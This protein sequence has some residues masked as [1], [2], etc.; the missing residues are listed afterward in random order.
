LNLKRELYLYIKVIKNISKKDLRGVNIYATREENII[1]GEGGGTSMIFV[2]T[3][4]NNYQMYNCNAMLRNNLNTE[5][6]KN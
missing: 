2:P 1:F 3:G 4:E 6:V 5:I